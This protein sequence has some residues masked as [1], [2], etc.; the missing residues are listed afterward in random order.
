M[1]ANSDDQTAT[2]TVELPAS[3]YLM[4][5]LV[6]FYLFEVI[7]LFMYDLCVYAYYEG[8]YVC[9]WTVYVFLCSTA[10]VFISGLSTR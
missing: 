1:G 5:Y 7:C 9:F 8:L 3:A 6:E 2:F 4:G 10:E